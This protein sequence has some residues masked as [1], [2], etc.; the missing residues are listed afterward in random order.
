M[1]QKSVSRFFESYYIERCMRYISSIVNK[2]VLKVLKSKIRKVSLQHHINIIK[3]RA[4]PTVRRKYCW[5]LFKEGESESKN[6]IS[7]LP[8]AH[9]NVESQCFH[10]FF[11][12]AMGKIG[13]DLKNFFF[14]HNLCTSFQKV[15][16][17]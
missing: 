10:T 13:L 16:F 14:P 17:E 6:L 9:K 3:L 4:A 1:W 12:I 11:N 8:S 15:S 2:D 5:E 7:D